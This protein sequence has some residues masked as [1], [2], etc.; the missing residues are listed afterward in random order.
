MALWAALHHTTLQMTHKYKPCL[1]ILTWSCSP[2]NV[3]FILSMLNIFCTIKLKTN[4]SNHDSEIPTY[5]LQMS[6]LVP[7]SRVCGIL[8]IVQLNP[9]K[10]FVMLFNTT[11]NANHPSAATCACHDMHPRQ[12]LAIWQKSRT[13]ITRVAS[14]RTENFNQGWHISRRADRN[15]DLQLCETNWLESCR[16]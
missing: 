4:F 9:N 11:A 6:V 16:V 10:P 7:R 1:V 13:P 2:V 12:W 3:E 14:A 8:R 5:V 15:N